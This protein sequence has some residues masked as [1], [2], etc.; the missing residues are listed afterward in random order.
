MAFADH[1]V[2]AGVALAEVGSHTPVLPVDTPMD[3]HRV[4]EHIPALVMARTKSAVD[5]TGHS[6]VD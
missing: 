6:Q 2:Q 1:Y 3:V 4:I 5:S